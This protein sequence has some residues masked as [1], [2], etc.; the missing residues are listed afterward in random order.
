MNDWK[1]FNPET[2]IK[3]N[4]SNIHQEDKQIIRRLV[5]FYSQHHLLKLGLD[6]GTGPNLYPLILML[7]ITKKIESI[8]FNRQNINY[9]KG[10]IMKMNRNWKRFFNFIKKIYKQSGINLINSLKTKV[11]I[12]QGDIY[13]LAEEKYDL[14][15]MFFC[16][17]SIT[18][19]YEK[20]SSVCNKLINS[21]KINGLI[22]AAFM[23]NSS[24]FFV[25]KIRHKTYL[26]NIKCLKKIF[27]PRVKNLKIYKIHKA[28]IPLRPGYTGILLLTAV[29]QR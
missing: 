10:Q 27:S 9:L 13:Q 14:V 19:D 6:I 5:K 16:A 7:P 17:E 21:V 11:I 25:G 3:H 18:N 8:D 1:N 15:S 22:V 29:R 24:Q 12:K 4:Y 23:E 2:Y 28:K 26:V 20:F